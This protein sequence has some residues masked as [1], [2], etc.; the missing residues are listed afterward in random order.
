ML[1]S[2]GQRII[3]AHR[4]LAAPA[5]PGTT[6]SGPGA[7]A[8]ADALAPA[9]LTAE[10]QELRE[11]P[12]P[13]QPHQQH[14]HHQAAGLMAHVTLEEARRRAV[15]LET[16]ARLLLAEAEETAQARL[17]EAG[18]RAE[19]ALARARAEAEAL[20]G[21]VRAE[22]FRAGRDAGYRDGIQA[23]RDEAQ[24]LLEQARAE[25]QAVAG[26]VRQETEHL[27][28]AARREREELMTAL[29]PEL[30]RLAVH[31]ARQIVHS[32]LTLRPEAIVHIL[33]AALAKLRGD[34]RAR[35]RV[36][37]DDYPRVEQNRHVL[38]AALPGGSE[39]EVVAD[40]GVGPG[41]FVVQTDQGTVDGRLDAQVAEVAAGLDPAE[42]DKG[43]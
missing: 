41:E 38:L 37:P 21:Q 9:L 34:D 28:R 13:P 31:I 18:Q 33:T 27:L 36:H 12:P 15:V 43:D 7:P 30:V 5:V 10:E 1:Y 29:E 16:R 4:A 39:I 22:G 11:W 20:L 26:R 23:A 19:E 40:P 8:P 17:A 35:V 24:G 3:K 42:L 25:A 32:E 2:E 14:P 6:L